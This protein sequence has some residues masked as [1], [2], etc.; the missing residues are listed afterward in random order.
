MASVQRSGRAQVLPSLCVARPQFDA[1]LRGATPAFAARVSSETF[2]TMEAQ[3]ILIKLQG[4]SAG[5]AET[6]ARVPLATLKTFSADVADLLRGDSGGP[7]LASLDVSI[8]AGSLG[9][10]T[11]PL[12]DSH[13]WSDLRA[14]VGSEMLDAISP[15]RRK[16]IERW[17]VQAKSRR[18]LR[19]E[20]SS[21]ALQRPIVISANSDYRTD[22]ADQWVRVER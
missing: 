6:P 18:A 20:I 22:D 9:I 19:F 17:Q 8:V 21:A 3:G 2:R 1:L 15:R 11:S 12:A 5:Y 13:L 10:R 16:V 14:L 7:D 4:E